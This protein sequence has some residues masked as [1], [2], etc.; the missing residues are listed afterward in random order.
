MGHKVVCLKC[1]KAFNITSDPEGHT[2]MKCSECNSKL[3]LF[4]H[5]FRPPKKSD[6][7]AWQVV[8]FLYQKGFNYQHILSTTAHNKS[9]S[10]SRSENYVEYP[11]NMREA[12][13]FVEKYKDQARDFNT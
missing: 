11:K 9:I 6:D 3:A 2:P 4:D 10:L 12:Q 8:G 7:K 1:Q 13:E 5:K